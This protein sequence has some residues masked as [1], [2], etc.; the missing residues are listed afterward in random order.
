MTV[1]V[2][3]IIVAVA[4]FVAM[5]TGKVKD[6]NNN[7]IPDAIEKPIEAVKNAVAEVKEVVEKAKKSTPKQEAPKATAPK[8]AAKK[9]VAKP[10]AKKA[11]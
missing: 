6:A 2:I 5:K 10:N 3:L 7:N 4:V 1:L 11:K 8:P 9:P